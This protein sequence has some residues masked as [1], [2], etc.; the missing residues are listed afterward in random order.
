MINLNILKQT[1]MMCG[2]YS[3]KMILSYYGIEKP[4]EEL[5][6]ELGAIPGFGCPTEDLLAGVKR[7]GLDVSYK[8]RSS[9]DDLK[10]NVDFG[11]PPIVLWFSPEEGGH[12]TPVVEFENDEI[13]L[14]DTL[15]GNL[16]RMKVVDFMNRWFELDDYPPKD[17]AKFV[18]RAAIAITPRK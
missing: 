6:K 3:V 5:I 11:I 15:L 4:I 7:L 10:A 14:A 13:I 2:P 9:I 1:P 8:E 18:L 16:R 12:Y 17:P